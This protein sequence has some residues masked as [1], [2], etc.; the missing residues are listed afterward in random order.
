[1]PHVRASVGSGPVSSKRW[2]EPNKVVYQQA[3]DCLV[4]VPRHEPFS[5]TLDLVFTC[6]LTFVMKYR[7]NRLTFIMF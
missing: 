5:A 4:T 2:P 7:R 1:L 6:R 3:D